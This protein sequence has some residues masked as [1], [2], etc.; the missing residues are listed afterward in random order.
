MFQYINFVRS[1]RF[2]YSLVRCLPGLSI[3]YV[4]PTEVYIP[5]FLPTSSSASNVTMPQK[6]LRTRG[7]DVRWYWCGTKPRLQS[8]RR[9][10]A[11]PRSNGGV[12]KRKRPYCSFILSLSIFFEI[13]CYIPRSFRYSCSI[14][15]SVVFP[16]V[17]FKYFSR[18]NA[19]YL[20]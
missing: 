8:L 15:R 6:G 3:L 10:N 17:V 9:A 7:V 13:E 16:F 1:A 2:W 18:R 19:S 11:R 20:C 5:E 14:L 12:R 4:V